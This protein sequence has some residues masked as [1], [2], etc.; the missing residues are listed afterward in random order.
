MAPRVRAAVAAAAGAFMKVG[1]GGTAR[2][3][4]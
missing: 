3:A 1:S 2:R 4:S